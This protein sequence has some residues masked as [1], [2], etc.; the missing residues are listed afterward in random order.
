FNVATTAVRGD[1]RLVAVVMGGFSAQSRDTH[2]ANL[3]DRGFM[4]ASLRDQQTWMANTNVAQEF[5]AFGPPALAPTQPAAPS[6]PVQRQPL[7][8]VVE[9]TAQSSPNTPPPSVDLEEQLANIAVIQRPEPSNAMAEPD[10]LRAFI[11]RER[12]LASVPDTGGSWGIQVGA[13][14]QE[15]QARQLA[16]QA[17]NRI[18]QGVGG[19]VEVDTVQGQTPVYRARLVALDEQRARQA[20]RELHSQGMD[21]MV[22]NASL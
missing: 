16:Q 17:A 8:A 15:M 22:V 11:E 4:R 12:Q 20:C 13:F 7:L 19:R 1:R 9:T 21:C 5:M 10:P 2:M 14:S 6:Q 18:G 3:L